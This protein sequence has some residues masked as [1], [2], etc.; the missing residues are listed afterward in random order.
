M[1]LEGIFSG[2]NFHNFDLQHELPGAKKQVKGIDSKFVVCQEQADLF[3]GVGLCLRLSIRLWAL[4]LTIVVPLLL[5]IVVPLLLT[6]VVPLLLTIVVPL[7]LTIVV[8]LLLTIVVPLLLTIVVPLLLT[9]VVPLILTQSFLRFFSPFVPLG[10]A[11]VL[12]S[13][14]GSR[15]S[16]PLHFAAQQGAEGIVQRLLEAKA[17]VDAENNYGRG[18]GRGFGGK[19][20]LGMGSLWGKWKVDEIL[21]VEVLGG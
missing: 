20:L 5:T 21:M 13:G 12:A 18:L 2:R 9:I 10:S 19:N 14:R 1:F 11:C 17:A 4:I 8:P 3:S 7:L 6:I 15:G 16:T